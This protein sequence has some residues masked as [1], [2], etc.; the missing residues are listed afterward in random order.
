MKL[1]LEIC[2]TIAVRSG[3]PLQFVF[4]DLHLMNILSK[5]AAAAPSESNSL[6][7]KGGT[8]LNKV[9]IGG[10]QRFS[11]DVDFDLISKTTIHDALS[12]SKGLAS[13]LDEYDV[14]EFRRIGN[15]VQF[16]CKYET[17]LGGRDNVRIDISPKPLIIAKPL[18]IRK[19]ES[20][21]THSSV[22]GLKIYAVEDLTARKMNA[23]ASR[24]EGKDLYDVSIALP[25]CS[26]KVLRKAVMCMLESEGRSIT[27][28][29]FVSR[30]K[31]RVK[32]SNVARLRNFT[33]PFIPIDRRPKDWGELKNNLLLKLEEL[34]L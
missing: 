31:E 8:A 23:L 11:E 14:N 33:N 6:V 9:Y 25:L 28:P 30:L 3:L 7:F 21:F 12:F 5:L 34:R 29:E 20:E 17:P 32:K 19:I 13:A 26:I 24:D 2:R 1:D 18:E 27:V 15:M 22:T 4:K 10:M 16:Y